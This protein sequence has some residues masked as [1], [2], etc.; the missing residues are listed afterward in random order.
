[1]EL[2]YDKLLER[3]R[4]I[5]PHTTGVLGKLA[6]SKKHLDE[7]IRGA[8]GI[9]RLAQDF[10]PRALERACETALKFGVFNY[11]AIRDLLE[12]AWNK[13]SAKPC[14]SATAELMHENVRGAAYYSGGTKH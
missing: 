5:G 14:V 3:A 1:L 11:R 7:V 12:Q 6:L 8:L 4:T 2:G 9:L 10:S 13:G